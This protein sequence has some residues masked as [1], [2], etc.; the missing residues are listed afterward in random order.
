MRRDRED[1]SG[2]S[3]EFGFGSGLDEGGGSR[4]KKISE[5]QERD[6]HLNVGTEIR[7][8]DRN[9]GFCS[10]SGPRFSDPRVNLEPA[11]RPFSDESCRAAAAAADG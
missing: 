11:W 2:E 6:S 4:S 1:V 5:T 10:L 3:P 9:R 8:R 7:Q